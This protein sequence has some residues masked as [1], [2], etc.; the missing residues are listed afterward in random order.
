MMKYSAKLKKPKFKK[1]P[2]LPPILANK[3]IKSIA[4]DSVDSV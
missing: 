1:S 2:K 4:G 3:E